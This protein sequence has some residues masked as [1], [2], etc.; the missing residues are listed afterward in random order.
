MLQYNKLPIKV[1]NTATEFFVYI[2]EYNTNV[3]KTN[4]YKTDVYKTN[5]HHVN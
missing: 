2:P 5:A 4:V 1:Q 3:Y